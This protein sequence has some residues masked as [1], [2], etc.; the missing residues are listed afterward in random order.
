MKSLYR[1]L[2][3]DTGFA[4][5]HL[6]QVSF[7]PALVG[8]TDFEAARR[9]YSELERRA[10]VVPGVNSA[11]LGRYPLLG[12]TFAVAAS[13]LTIDGNPQEEGPPESWATR[14]AVDPNYFATVGMELTKG[15]NF[16]DSDHANAQKVAIVN[17]QFVRQYAPGR[18]PIGMRIGWNRTAD[19]RIVGVV[20]N[21]KYSGIREDPV[22]YWY[23][24][25]S[26][27][28]AD[29][30]PRMTLHLRITTP[31]EAVVN[32]IRNELKRAAAP[33]ATTKI[34]TIEST[35][36]QNAANERLAGLLAAFSAL[37]AAVLTALG[38]YA[39]VSQSVVRRT[40]EIGVRIALGA[41]RVRIEWL[42]VG[43]VGFLIVVGSIIG[44]TIA[45]LWKGALTSF[46]F[47]TYPVDP[48]VIAG[49]VL[50]VA[51]TAAGAALGPAR[52]ASRC[53]IVAALRCD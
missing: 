38:I 3:Q 46:L 25:Y 35:I 22:P 13:P 49:A 8:Q 32:E 2:S 29:R 26:Q 48:S 19:T 4:R 30:W 43:E 16:S 41:D 14:N 31:A 47:D 45:L 28:P 50:V 15:R 51:A 44:V 21:A 1:L 36:R 34:E 18:D 27:L 40:R 52:R 39:L 37:F 33:I 9:F 11:A 12:R 53:D 6:L 10:A 5:D 23:I 17:E 42:L 20:R 7:D 24:P